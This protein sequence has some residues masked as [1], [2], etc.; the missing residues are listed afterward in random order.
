M[1]RAQRQ[2]RALGERLRTARM[3]R[4]ITQ[5]ELAARVGVSV[6]TIGKLEAG[7]VSTSF[8]TVVRVLTALGWMGISTRSRRRMR[9][10]ANSW[11]AACVARWG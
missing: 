1:P 11:T 2:L 8:S 9:W 3:R 5:G 10:G 4:E 7:D 6:P